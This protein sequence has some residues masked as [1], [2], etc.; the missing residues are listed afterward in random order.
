MPRAADD[1]INPVARSFGIV[2]R[3]RRDGLQLSQEKLA[4]AAEIDRTYVSM[5]E[6][7]IHQPSLDVFIRVARALDVTPE[8]M[9]AELTAELSDSS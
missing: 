3:R 8:R 2:L 1:E 7:G 4:G 5:M 6:R 9:M